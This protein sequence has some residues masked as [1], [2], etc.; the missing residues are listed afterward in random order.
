QIAYIDSL[1]H[2]LEDVTKE[3]DQLLAQD[4]PSLNESLKP[5]GQQ[6]IEPPPAKI[7]GN[8]QPKSSASNAGENLSTDKRSA[9]LTSAGG[10]VTASSHRVQNHSNTWFCRIRAVHLS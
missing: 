7:S 4:L 2:E 3:F 5:K 1:K 10:S 8:E 9:T 6:P